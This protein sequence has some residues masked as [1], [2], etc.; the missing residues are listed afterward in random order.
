MLDVGIGDGEFTGKIIAALSPGVGELQ[1]TG[2]DPDT[3]N[4]DRARTRF[5][6]G[7]LFNASLNEFVARDW[8]LNPKFDVVLASHSLYYLGEPSDALWKLMSLVRPGGTLL[9]SLWSQQCDLHRLAHEVAPS[10]KNSISVESVTTQ[11]R[12]L[13]GLP[14]AGS[15]ELSQ[16]VWEGGVDFRDWVL[17]P[18]ALQAANHFFSR[19]ILP[20]GRLDQARQLAIGTV[21]LTKTRLT[22][23]QHAWFTTGLEPIILGVGQPSFR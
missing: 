19:S 1:I 22:A 18:L 15:W 16:G 10:A 23:P 20:P 3:Q 12:G 9:I 21:K 7:R 11:L 6:D 5:P 17:T 14:G 13:A 4:I 8:N 2:V